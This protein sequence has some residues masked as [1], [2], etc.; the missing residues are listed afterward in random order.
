VSVTLGTVLWLTMPCALNRAHDCF[1]H[2]ELPPYKSLQQCREKLAKA[3][4]AAPPTSR[5]S[6]DPALGGGG[7][8]G[9]NTPAAPSAPALTPEEDAEWRMG[10]SVCTVQFEPPSRVC[11]WDVPK[12]SHANSALFV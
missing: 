2:I 7:P 12:L 3:I 6:P 5:P 8:G 4:G 1:F 11:D 9:A 10:L